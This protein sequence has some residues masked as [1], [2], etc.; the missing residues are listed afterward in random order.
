MQAIIK[1][2]HRL[3]AL[4]ASVAA[5]IALLG[6]PN[7]SAA[8]RRPLAVMPD[9]SPEAMAV[10]KSAGVDISMIKAYLA[11]QAESLSIV[12]MQSGRMDPG[13]PESED[14][15]RLYIAKLNGSLLLLLSV[16][17]GYA[18]TNMLE[19]WEG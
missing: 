18:A 14:F 4:I 9:V 5:V 1:R 2:L 17:Q 11:Q 19:R 10:L 16:E 3:H 7:S 12:G 6:A 15:F 8:E 13:S